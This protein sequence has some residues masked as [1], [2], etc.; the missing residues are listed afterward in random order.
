MCIVLILLLIMILTC[1]AR[2]SFLNLFS[3]INC[4]KLWRSFIFKARWIA[5]FTIKRVVSRWWWWF[6]GSWWCWNYNIFL[7]RCGIYLSASWWISL[8]LMLNRWREKWLLVLNTRGFWNYNSVIPW[9][10]IFTL[11]S[12]AQFLTYSSKA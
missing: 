3:I 4:L 8:I 2:H 1:M 12:L 5:V 9:Y 7:R 10:I 11:S 6:R